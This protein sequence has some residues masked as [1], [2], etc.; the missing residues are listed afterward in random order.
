MAGRTT[1]GAFPTESGVEFSV[2]APEAK[3]LQAVFFD[4]ESKE[5]G[6]KE[7]QRDSEGI[8]KGTFKDA[9]VGTRYK[10]MVGDQ[11]PFPDPASRFQPEGVHGPSQVVDSNSFKWTDQN[12]KGID[13][14]DKLTIYELHVGTFTK[15]GTYKA[16][17]SKLPYL[18]ELGV[19]TIEILPLSD[20]PGRWNWGY[21]GVALYSP[22]RAYGTPEELRELVNAAHNQGL[23][24]LIDLVY[25]HLGP[26]GNYLSCY[27]PRYFTKKHDTPWGA[28][29]NYDRSTKTDEDSSTEVS[30]EDSKLDAQHATNVRKYVVENGL[31]YIRDFHFDGARLDATHAIIDYSTPHVLQDLVRTCKSA[32]NRPIYFFAEDDRNEA[33]LISKENGLDGL[34][35]DDFHHQV[36]VH[37]NGD[38]ESY[39]ANFTGSIEDLATT[40]RKGWFYVGQKTPTTGET[41][42][43]DPSKLDRHSHSCNCIQN[44]DQIGNRAMGERLHHQIKLDSY[45]AASS[46]L[47]LSPEV[48]MIFEG[49]EWATSSPFQFFTDHNADLGKLVTEGR[50]KEFGKFAA[51]N[52]PKIREKIPDP[53]AE[54]TFTNSKVNWEERE[55]GNHAAV[56]NLYR[57]LYQLRSKEPALHNARRN[58]LQVDAV[59]E[60]VLALT[61]KFEGASTIVSVFQLKGGEKTIDLG[62]LKGLSSSKFETVLTSQ[63]D[64]YK[65]DD[66][67][68][69]APKLEGSKL[70]F[71]GPSA[72]V[73]RLSN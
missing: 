61:R 13:S 30:A 35:A 44:H 15:E 53:Q 40:I 25:N 38:N 41:R 71:F 23:A 29:L 39:F 56:Y 45:K 52:D 55:S 11:G 28:A 62:S 36:R 1:F 64:K 60:T 72:V 6:R 20:F 34:W 37:T 33:E 19:N 54:S 10:Y 68:V 65:T 73:L 5:T 66:S 4:K 47:L 3:T 46:L 32:V 31:Y 42:G 59:D 12:W 67:K 50:R 14:L 2:W 58:D 7:L 51:F 43:T 57:D 21:D 17:Q 48:P 22:C 63:D 24:V 27:N 26:D 49:Q 16:L 18:K 8:W 9:S 70:T 69:A